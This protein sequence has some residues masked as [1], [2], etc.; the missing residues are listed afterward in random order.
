MY[1]PERWKIK[2]FSDVEKRRGCLFAVQGSSPWNMCS[3]SE[4]SSL[5]KDTCAVMSVVTGL[6]AVDQ[7]HCR[8]LNVS[9]VT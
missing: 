9:K 8:S 3:L 7:V 2:L 4:S 6:T 1:F 5:L